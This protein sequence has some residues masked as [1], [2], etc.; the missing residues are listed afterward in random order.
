[1][2]STTTNSSFSI[3]SAEAPFE[4]ISTK[5]L[6]RY[7]KAGQDAAQVFLSF[8][9]F[10]AQ[11]RDP[12][13]LTRLQAANIRVQKTTEMFQVDG[14]R[15]HTLP[16]LVMAMS[17]FNLQS[18][19]FRTVARDAFNTPL[20]KWAI[21]EGP[22]IYAV[23][24]SVNRRNGAFLSSN[25]ID[26][27]ADNM[28]RY[29]TA[30]QAL[31]IPSGLRTAQQEATIA[32]ATAVDS[33]ILSFS[34][35]GCRSIATDLDFNQVTLVAERLRHQASHGRRVNPTGNTVQIQSPL[36]IKYSNS[37]SR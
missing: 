8:A 18:I 16:S 20:S 19:L 26:N 13:L 28:D 2:N 22:R 34:A 14:Q 1:M 25:E 37:L 4:N 30:Y 32:F 29:A 23:G 6:A 3:G 31:K 36:Y 35:S 7:R 10:I 33:S 9:D 21:G 27:L 17:S 15:E 11:F 12:T 5:I 24:I